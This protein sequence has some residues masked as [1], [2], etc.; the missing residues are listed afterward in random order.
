MVKF[1]GETWPMVQTLQLPELVVFRLC[2][3]T[4]LSQ[5]SAAR[6]AALKQQLQ[7]V[8]SESGGCQ[9]GAQQDKEESD[10]AGWGKKS[11]N[12]K[13]PLEP[14]PCQTLSL[15]SVLC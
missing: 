2:L 10:K 7:Q 5:G 13:V 8:G 1:A 6:S 4:F 15:S 14:W 3:P 11:Q 12:A 9:A